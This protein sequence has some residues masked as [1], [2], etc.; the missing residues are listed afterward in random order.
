MESRAL[1]FGISGFILGGLLVS[2]A[3]TTF[4]KSDT[5]KTQT[6]PGSSTMSM[7]QMAA[8]LTNKQGDAYDEAFI[9][10]MIEHHQ[11]A[12]N[13]ANLSPARAKHNE[14][15]QLSQDIIMAQEKEIKQMKAWQ[16]D[17]GYSTDSQSHSTHGSM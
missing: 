6:S 2:M 11:A 12:V 8:S 14:I 1:L 5:L 17:W 15:K 3:A 7:E 10:S 16:K 13:M 4:E 9:A